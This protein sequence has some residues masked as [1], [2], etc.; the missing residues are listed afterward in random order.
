MF[1]YKN[2]IDSTLGYAAVSQ[3][4]YDGGREPN[5]CSIVFEQGRTRNAERIELFAN[6]R[7]CEVV[8]PDIYLTSE[9]SRQVTFSPSTL[10]TV[11]RQAVTEYQTFATHRRQSDGTIRSNLLTAAYLDPQDPNFF[12]AVD[13]P[14]AVYSHDIKFTPRDQFSN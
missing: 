6:A 14:V 11:A 1:N 12:K 4:L 2:L 10:S 5:R 8:T 13:Q 7:A 3:V 9:A